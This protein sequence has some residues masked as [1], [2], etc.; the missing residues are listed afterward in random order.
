MTFAE[1][2]SSA[3]EQ[4]QQQRA[5]YVAALSQEQLGAIQRN[6]AKPRPTG[7]RITIER[8]R[9]SVVY[10]SQCP[11]VGVTRLIKGAK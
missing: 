8:E 1:A 4:Y 6:A 11:Y 9:W 3:K 10:R 7:R 5:A 2:L